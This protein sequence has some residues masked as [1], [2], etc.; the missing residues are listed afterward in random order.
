ML[1]NDGYLIRMQVICKNEEVKLLIAEKRGKPHLIGYIP[2]KVCF[3]VYESDELDANND[4]GVVKLPKG[5]K[6]L[7]DLVKGDVLQ[8]RK[9]GMPGEMDSSIY[10]NHH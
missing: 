1:D 2:Q 9:N 3:C 5:R 8:I 10:Q 4:F 6:S 7:D